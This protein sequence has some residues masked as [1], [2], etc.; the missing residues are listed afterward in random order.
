MAPQSRALPPGSAACLAMCYVPMYMCSR[1]KMHAVLRTC[2]ITSIRGVQAAPPLAQGGNP[3]QANLTPDPMGAAFW[4]F[5]APG[6]TW[7]RCL[8]AM[9]PH[10][11]AAR[12][13]AT[14][15][16][17]PLGLSNREVPAAVRSAACV[18]R[19][20]AGATEPPAPAQ[21]SRGRPLKRALPAPVHIDSVCGLLFAGGKPE[22]PQSLA[23]PSPSVLSVLAVALVISAPRPRG[24]RQSLQVL[25]Q[26]RVRRGGLRGVHGGGA[27]LAACAAHAVRVPGRLMC[28][29]PKGVLSLRS[30]AVEAKSRFDGGAPS[31][32]AGVRAAFAYE[33]TCP[34]AARA[35]LMPLFLDPVCFIGA[36]VFVP[37]LS[38]SCCYA[39]AYIVRVGAKLARVPP[40]PSRMESLRLPPAF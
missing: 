16:A 23:L 24:R 8:D 30:D 28:Y 33:I 2:A 31:P 21:T 11:A 36:E 1:W 38:L 26:V 10:S 22:L 35:L 3:L 37:V 25:R 27:P 18:R 4:S 19:T 15:E 7:R 32:T 12:Q 34:T 39:A 14:A 9:Q 17:Q 40:D 13:M 5:M 20:D 29:P 6:N